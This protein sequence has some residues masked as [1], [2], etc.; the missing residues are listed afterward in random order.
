MG[1]YALAS[2]ILA[3]IPAF[4]I[5]ENPPTP[6]ST[7]QVPR[8]QSFRTSFRIMNQNPSLQGL[9]II[10]SI[11]WGVLMT[12]FI[13]I[14]EISELLGFNDSTGFLGI[15]MFAGGMVGAIV[16]PALSDRYRRRKLFF[17]FCNVCSIPGILLLVFCQQVG[18]VLLS[19]EAIA[20]IGASIVGLSLLASIPIGSQYA[21]EL[22]IG[23]SE[24]VIQGFLLLFS[25]ASCAVI[26]LISLVATDEYSPMLLSSLAALLAASM[27]GSSFLKESEMIVTEEE[28]LKDAIEQEIVHLQ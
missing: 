3:L 5:R 1:I 16:L 23:I 24:E 14:D 11:G 25:Q 13:K 22:G 26:M 20:M 10:F 6:S 27:I 12:L 17:V 9:M 18:A 2:S 28:R 4:L 19:S 21:A 8:N 7:L 15:A